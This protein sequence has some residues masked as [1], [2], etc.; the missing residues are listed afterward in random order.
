MKNLLK[1]ITYSWKYQQIPYYIIVIDFMENI[2]SYQEKF[3]YNRKNKCELSQTVHEFSIYEN[4]HLV[5]FLPPYKIIAIWK[6]LFL[7]TKL[8]IF[9]IKI[10]IK[11]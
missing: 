4:C 11:L 1:F 9:M 3:S 5:S 10:K 2:K 6:C 8:K 7:K